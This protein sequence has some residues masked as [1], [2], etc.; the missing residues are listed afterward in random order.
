MYQ[1][2]YYP[3]TDILDKLQAHFPNGFVAGGA[4]RDGI[5]GLEPQDY[6]I[7]F[8]DENAAVSAYEYCKHWL[9]EQ[10]SEVGSMFGH[11]FKWGKDTLNIITRFYG[12]PEEVIS[13]F[14]FTCCQV[15]WKDRCTFALD[16]QVEDAI[17]SKELIP[18]PAI[19]DSVYRLVRFMAR[20]W[21]ATPE[22]INTVVM[23]SVREYKCRM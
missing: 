23:A 3:S 20:G 17:R 2:S 7:F 22:T 5:L 14:D 12:K 15:Y 21:Y 6:D 8:P 4:I 13:M 19:R 11:K 9:T 10:S 18:T 16:E 1:I